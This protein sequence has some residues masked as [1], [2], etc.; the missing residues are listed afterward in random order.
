[1]KKFTIVMLAVL[2][3]MSLSLGGCKTMQKFDK[4]LKKSL[5][6]SDKPLR[7]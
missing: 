1:M 3:G 6:G 2:V 4:N 5:S 7:V